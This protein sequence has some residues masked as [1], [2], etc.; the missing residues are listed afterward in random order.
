MKKIFFPFIAFLLTININAQIISP[1]KWEY[2]VKKVSVSEYELQAIAIID[3]P[4]HLYGQYFDD[5]GPIKLQFK[6]EENNTYE[7]IGKTLESP[8]P[9][10]V[11]DEIFN[12]DVHYFA[13]KALF[14]QKVKI[15]KAT[16][17]KVELEGQVCNDNTGMCVMVSDEH[18]FKIK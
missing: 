5:G 13:D 18:T 11:R 7:L 17:I 8:K 16:E 14:I 1:V 2:K 15:K 3:K 9:K 10:V 6:F 4:W 12:I